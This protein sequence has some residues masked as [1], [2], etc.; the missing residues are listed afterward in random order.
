MSEITYQQNDKGKW[1]VLKSGIPVNT[2]GRRVGQFSTQ[3]AA[4]RYAERR[5]GTK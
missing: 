5:F 3:E 1:L 2:V 4:Q